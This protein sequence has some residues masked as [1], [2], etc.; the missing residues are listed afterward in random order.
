[1][2]ICEPEIRFIEQYKAISRPDQNRL[3]S[4]LSE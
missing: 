2:I 1:M 3:M 4:V